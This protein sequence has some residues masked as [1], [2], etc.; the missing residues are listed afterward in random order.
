MAT[1]LTIHSRARRSTVVKKVIMAVTGLIMI[2]FLLM[3]MYGNLK[4]FYQADNFHAFD[5]Y[6][7]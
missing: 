3:H 7:H 4:M 6:A 5:H 1:N 2:G